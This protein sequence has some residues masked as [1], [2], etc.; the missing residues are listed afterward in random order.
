[1]RDL[2][3][4]Y[5]HLLYFWTVAREGSIAKAC[6]LLKVAQPTIS[7]QIA[8]LE[9]HLKQKLFL[10]VGR[11]LT[12]TDV[13]QIAFEYAN[14]IFGLGRDL[15]NA[16]N[17]RTQGLG[18]RVTV[19]VADVIPKLIAYRILEPVFRMDEPVHL[20]C[21]EDKPDRLLTELAGHRLDLIIT[22]TQPSPNVKVKVFHHL[23]GDC[24][25][26][27]FGTSKLAKA[28]RPKF[29]QS[30]DGQPFLLPTDNTVLRRSLDQWFE[31]NGVVPQ[32]VAEFADMALLKVFGQAGKG[33]F[34]MPSVV[35]DTIC[36]QYNV[37][38]IGTLTDVREKFYAVTVERRIKHP[39]VILLSQTARTNLFA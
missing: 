7:A 4:N 16:V 6:D 39:A 20:V 29:P 36:E 2:E 19:G 12:L 38:K 21:V 24:P 10:R 25:V 23:L 5:H 1:M 30:L 18:L 9:E 11:N 17:G 22:D 3:L 26:T 28:I 13:G 14:E 37:E 32:V 15:V 35:D 34:A 33:V 31:Q 8:A 27:F